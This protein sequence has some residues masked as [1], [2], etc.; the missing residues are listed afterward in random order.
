MVRRMTPSQYLSSR[1][2][3][4]AKAKRQFQQAV[5]KAKQQER[6]FVNKANQEIR[7]AN[8]ARKR[9]ID[10]Y[11]RKIRSH[12]SRVRANRQKLQQALTRLATQRISARFRELHSSVTVLSRT[13]ERLDASGN[14][15]YFSDLAEQ[16]TANSV[17]VLNSLLDPQETSD[18]SEFDLTD[19]VIVNELAHVSPELDGRWRGAVFALDP[20]N[21]DA[22][23]HFCTSA[24][25]I[26]TTI[27]DVKAP[28]GAVR[29]N[30]PDCKLTAN[31]T[32]TRR[33]KI[34]YCLSK[35]GYILEDLE[36]FVEAN[37]DNALELFSTLSAGTHGPS[38]RY[39]IAQLEAIKTRVE[40]SI[41]F[42][43]EIVG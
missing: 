32:P 1:R 10:A 21:P 4:E 9:D 26:V 6:H 22:A 31:G 40:D 18:D 42:M 37:I 17:S 41:R 23:R 25:E 24:R 30:N 11:N 35:R 20:A 16:E 7:K 39:N 8:T 33:A 27:L 43:C 19:T 15:P 28:D 36:D 34:Q 3:A 2:Q 38:G 14:A 5:A 29:A 13:Y 12:N